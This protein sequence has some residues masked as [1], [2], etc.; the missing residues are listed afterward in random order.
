[1]RLASFPLIPTARQYDSIMT[2]KEGI[3]GNMNM[4]RVVVLAIFFTVAPILVGRAQAEPGQVGVAR[5]QELVDHLKD[6]IREAEQDR[7]SN[8]ATTRQLRDLVRRYDW[9]WRISLLFDD[10]HDGDF[11]YDPRWIV[12]HGEFRVTRGSGLRSYFDPTPS[13]R[14]RTSERR[15]DSPALELLGELLLSGRERAGETQSSWRSEAE[16]FTRVGITKAFAL[17]LQLNIKNYVDRN[18]R[19]EFG[20]YQGEERSSGYRLAYE[21]GQSPSLSLL[22]VGPN[23]SAVIEMVD[24]G[25]VLDDGAAHTIEWRRSVDGEMVVLL[26]NREVIRGVDRAYDDPF[27][28]FAIIN[29]GGEFEIKQ[30]SIFGTH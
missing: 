10:F 15:T 3:G 2:N 16:I 20:P 6:V 12:N 25:T 26:D 28:G 13:G 24:R 5:T 18:T 22:R 30:I 29:K 11:T 7:R 4:R 17:K 23:R 1:M 21:S 9:P 27:D 19:L 14:Y 8:P